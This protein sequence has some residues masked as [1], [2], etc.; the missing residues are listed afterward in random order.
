M[1]NAKLN[2]N[3]NVLAL[4]PGIKDLARHEKNTKSWMNS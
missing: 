2:L 3:N 4:M 1:S